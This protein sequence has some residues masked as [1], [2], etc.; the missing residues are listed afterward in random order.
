[1]SGSLPDPIRWREASDQSRLAERAAGRV[2]RELASCVPLAS[3]Q[4][5]RIKARV[6]APARTRVYVHFWLTVT[7]S[8]ILGAATAASAARLHWLPAW[9]TGS[10][11]ASA[12]VPAR[13][14]AREKMPSRAGQTGVAVTGEPARPHVSTSTSASTWPTPAVGAPVGAGA[15]P[16]PPVPAPSPERRGARSAKASAGQ[17]ERTDG[18]RAWTVGHPAPATGEDRSGTGLAPSAPLTGTALSPST[19]PDHGF[20]APSLAEESRPSGAAN[21]GAAEPLAEAIRTLRTEHAPAQAL[22]VLDAH[23]AEVARGGLGHE[24][25]LVRVEALLAI[26]REDEVLRLLDL[27]PLDDVAA[28]RSLR[29]VRGELRAAFGRCTEALADFDRLLTAPGPIRERALRGR[30]SCKAKR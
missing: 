21:A 23:S 20:A 17:A 5:V 11:P 19:S 12:V 22:A 9:T 4:L 29:I 24:A 26:Q 1:M 15:E 30:D 25:L 10:A 18:A 2:A 27:T 13:K 6:T 8:L 3:L 16:S 14:A 7:A 28:S